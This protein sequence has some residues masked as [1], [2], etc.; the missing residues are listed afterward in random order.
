[1]STSGKIKSNVYFRKNQI[2][3]VLPEKLNQKTILRKKKYSKTKIQEF[4]VF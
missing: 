4:S 2:K 3:C 1:M